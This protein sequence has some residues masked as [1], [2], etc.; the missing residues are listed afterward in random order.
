MLSRIEWAALSLFCAIGCS[1]S[2]TPSVPSSAIPNCNV[3]IC[4]ACGDSRIVFSSEGGDL[5]ISNDDLSESRRLTST[6]DIFEIQPALAPN[7]GTV[8]YSGRRSDG[9]A[10]NLFTLNLE[11]NNVVQITDNASAFDT[12]PAFSRDGSL[13]V[14]ARA[15]KLRNYSMGGKTWDDWDL[16]IIGSEGGEPKRLTNEHYRRLSRPCFLDNGQTVLFAAGEGGG[17]VYS[18]L[19]RITIDSKNGPEPLATK[20]IPLNSKSRCLGDEPAVSADGKSVIFISDCRKPYDYELWR[21]ETSDLKA[22]PVLKD[23]NMQN[24]VCPILRSDS[25]VLFLG[26]STASGIVSGLWSSDAASE[27]LRCLAPLTLFS[28]SG[29]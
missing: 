17:K 6:F 11:S 1:G 27:N 7:D 23:A 2:S 19:Y 3:T 22:V 18:R 15:H 4:A 24:E 9:S 12:S 10:A 14:F 20:H 29:N 13:V 21:L 8:A 26:V 28:G 25:S 5:Y 16:Y